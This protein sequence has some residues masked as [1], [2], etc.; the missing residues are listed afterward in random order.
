MMAW[1]RGEG[2]A[3]VGLAGRDG[4]SGAGLLRDEYKTPT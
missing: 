2:E 3:R 4:L 1:G